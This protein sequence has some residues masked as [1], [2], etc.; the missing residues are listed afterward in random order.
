MGYI[1]GEGR[2]QGTL[3]PVVL[4]DLALPGLFARGSSRRNPTGHRGPFAKGV[5]AYGIAAS[6][7]G[8]AVCGFTFVHTLAIFPF[9][10]MRNVFRLAMATPR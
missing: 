1:R 4:D 10:S 2:S 3:F 6:T 7:S 9:G 5:P 8:A